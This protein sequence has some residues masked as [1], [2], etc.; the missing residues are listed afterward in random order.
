MATDYAALIG[1]LQSAKRD[2]SLRKLNLSSADRAT[3]DQCIAEP[4]LVDALDRQEAQMVLRAAEAMQ[5]DRAERGWAE[6][7]INRILS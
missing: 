1:Q 4:E 3:L 6:M 7:L 2:Q 5:F